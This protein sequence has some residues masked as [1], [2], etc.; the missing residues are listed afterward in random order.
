V[1]TPPSQGRFSGIIPDVPGGLALGAIVGVGVL[2]V[3]AVM[4]GGLPG[5]GDSGTPSGEAQFEVTNL[6][7]PSEVTAGEE[8]NVTVSV[9]NTGETA[10]NGTLELDAGVLGN[11]SE[12]V[13]EL[14]SGGEAVSSEFSFE[15]DES[16]EYEITATIGNA[17]DTVAVSVVP[18][19]TGN[20]D[21]DPDPEPAR[22]TLDKLDIAGQQDEAEFF[23][24]EGGSVSV[25]VTNDGGQAG[26]FDVDLEVGDAS[27][28][29]STGEL[30]SGE[31]GTVRFDD[32]LDDLRFGKY[33]VT[34][35]AGDKSVSGTLDVLADF[36]VSI[37]SNN[38]TAGENLVIQ[39]TLNDTGSINPPISVELGVI[40]KSTSDKL[41]DRTVNLSSTGD[42]KFA[43][44]IPTGP[45]DFG[46]YVI[47]AT[48][49]GLDQV[50]AEK[51][52]TIEADQ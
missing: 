36:D 2:V 6:N 12:S 3:L 31:T 41:D 14:E 46:E 4:V 30:D 48:P 35:S 39:A 7:V 38:I 16:D 51:E 34:V 49:V 9:Q 44:E 18:A 1:Q 27:E 37:N 24:S 47:R 5:G 45:E 8:F 32:V 25:N 13:E 19:D 21:P 11:E 10:G 20:G 15:T 43:K 28:T 42:T 17:T 23:I 29:G 40:N 33:D 50:I 26:S 52:V 22:P